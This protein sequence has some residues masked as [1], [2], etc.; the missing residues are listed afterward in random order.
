MATAYPLREDNFELE[1]NRVREKIQT[2]FFE[3]I[4][5]LK[6]R[7]NE[8]LIQL[9]TVLASY[10]SYRDELERVN[11][12]K[13]DLTRTKS[14]LQNEHPTSPITSHDK[15]ISQ[16][17]T[18]LS[19]IATPIEPK[20]V[21][22]EC[23]SNKM[24]AE[25]NKLGKLAERE[26]S[27]I[28]Y[29]SKKQPLVS[30]YEK[31]KKKNQLDWA[32]GLTV[33]N[34]TGNIYIADCSNNCVKVFDSTGKYLLKFGDKNTEGKM[35]RPRGVAIN[36]DIILITQVNHSIMCYELEGI[37]ICEIGR[38]GA[39]E[40]QFNDPSGLTINES[41]GDIYICDRCNNR[42]EIL[43]E[44]FSFKTQF[45]KGQI[46]HPRDVKL[47]KEYI[48]VL[49]ESNPCLHLFSY[50]YI[51]QKRG[52]S[53]GAGLNVL[54]SCFFFIDRTNN[55][56]ISDRL[57]NFILIFSSEF[58]LFHKIPVSNY[59]TGVTVD[60]QGRVIVVCQ[61]DKNCLQIY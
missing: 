52:I 11:G 20:M 39:G 1:L 15:V 45:G 7:E 49:D 44:D 25:L 48:Y 29:T 13:R 35:Y 26:R 10:L 40:A 18:Q 12:E 23:D 27:E 4:D 33:D 31:G 42:V 38:F 47:S 58:Q 14:L 32:L 54:Y 2:K 30:V 24:L 19:S 5:C 9:D 61:A 6:A 8:L 59:P 36:G 17:T 28:D 53:R 41:N 43:H 51:L 50:D 60:N 57:S 22:F 34:K 37:F 56:V 55:I 16:L 3:L 46:L 21:T